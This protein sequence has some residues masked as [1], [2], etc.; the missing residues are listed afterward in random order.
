MRPRV[1]TCLP[2]TCWTRTTWTTARWRRVRELTSSAGF[3]TLTWWAGGRCRW[4]VP[5]ARSF[6]SRRTRDRELPS[7]R[8]RWPGLYLAGEITEDSSLNGAIR[9]GE[10]AARIVANDLEWRP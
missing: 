5:R 2:R 10:A 3:P 1:G 4:C 7:T 8:T 6:N 9:S